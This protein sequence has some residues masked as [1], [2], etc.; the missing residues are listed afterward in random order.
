VANTGRSNRQEKGRKENAK[1][2]KEIE[3]APVIAGYECD[4]KESSKEIRGKEA[5]V[6]RRS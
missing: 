5:E 2:A 4:V 6:T 3:V 1:F